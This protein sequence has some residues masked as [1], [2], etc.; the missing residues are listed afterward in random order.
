MQMSAPHLNDH[1][2]S[3][4]YLKIPGNLAIALVVTLNHGCS[5][6]ADID[7]GNGARRRGA[8]AC[9]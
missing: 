8:G 1:L 9:S 6:P 7:V 5:Q 2:S 4:Q 3:Y